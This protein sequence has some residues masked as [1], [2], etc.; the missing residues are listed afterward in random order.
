MEINRSELYNNT[1]LETN[2]VAVTRTRNAV[3]NRCRQTGLVVN[4]SCVQGH[5]CCSR[6]QKAEGKAEVDLPH[7]TAYRAVRKM[8][9]QLYAIYLL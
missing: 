8:H 3:Q 2:L 4:G 5:R 6:Q 7:D 9:A 1:S